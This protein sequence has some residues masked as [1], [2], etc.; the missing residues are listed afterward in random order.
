MNEKL[1]EIN[2]IDQYT[3]ELK[4]LEGK[5]SN[6]LISDFNSA[7]NALSMSLQARK[8]KTSLDKSKAEIMRPVLDYQKSINKIV[9]DFQSTL[10]QIEDKLKNSIKDW[11]SVQNKNPFEQ[12]QDIEVEDGKLFYKKVW[13]Y[14]I[15]NLDEIPDKYFILDESLLQ[16]DI[17]SGIRHI[18]GV[19]VFQSEEISLRVK[20]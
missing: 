11:I 17:D 8:L 2:G 10:I 19:E 16:N 7:K 4:L 12:I 5:S 13:Q 9:K 3:K 1:T 14:K 20:N 6:F 18:K 15:V